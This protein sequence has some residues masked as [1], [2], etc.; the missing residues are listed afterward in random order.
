L[1]ETS[2]SAGGPPPG[3]WATLGTT[4]PPQV[5]PAAPG[6]HITHNGQLSPV[7]QATIDRLL[8]KK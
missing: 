2:S 7:S 3:G 8:G 6:G 1:A 5:V 4:L